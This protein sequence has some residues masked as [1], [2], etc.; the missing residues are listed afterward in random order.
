MIFTKAINRTLVDK[1]V[2]VKDMKFALSGFRIF[3]W[4]ITFN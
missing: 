3:S 1:L 2:L 4:M